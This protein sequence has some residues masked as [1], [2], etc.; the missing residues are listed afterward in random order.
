MC[1]EGVFSVRFL[2]GENKSFAGREIRADTDAIGR[3]LSIVW[4]EKVDTC[5]QGRVW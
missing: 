2:V 5:A 3:A 1:G 4:F